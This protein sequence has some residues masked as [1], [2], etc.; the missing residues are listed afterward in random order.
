MQGARFSRMIQKFEYFALRLGAQR[1]R[2]LRLLAAMPGTFYSRFVTW[3]EK[4][5]RLAPEDD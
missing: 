5:L 2:T 4:H 1:E 3:K